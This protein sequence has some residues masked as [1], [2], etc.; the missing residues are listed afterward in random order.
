MAQLASTPDDDL[1]AFA[2]PDGRSLRRGVAFIAPYIE[3]KN[4]WPLPP[5]V[6]YWDACPV[7]HPSLLLAGIHFSHTDYLSLWQRFESDSR[8]Y[9]VLRNLPLR[10]PLLWVGEAFR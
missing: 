8:L 2:L 9:E 1:W 10:H 7:R 5:D 6:M 4:R 3:D